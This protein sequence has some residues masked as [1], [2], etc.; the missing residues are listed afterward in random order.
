MTTRITRRRP[1][2]AIGR[3]IKFPR[4]DYQFQ[5]VFPE[6]AEPLLYAAAGGSSEAREII[7]MVAKFLNRVH[8]VTPS[9]LC[10]LCDN[11][12]PSPPN[13]TKYGRQDVPG[14]IV[15]MRTWMAGGPSI[16]N[17]L[18]RQ[19]ARLDSGELAH[20]ILEAYRRTVPKAGFHLTSVSPGGAA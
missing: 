7:S 2:G 20:R 6:H 17:G 18:C 14:A 8:T 3:R 15:V 12:L 5:V 19:C 10:L 16:T 9:A 1:S 11:E 13:W 4:G